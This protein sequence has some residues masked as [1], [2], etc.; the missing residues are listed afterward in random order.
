MLGQIREQRAHVAEAG[1]VNQIATA[2]LAADQA[3]V[4]EFLQMKRQRAR[5]NSELF[6]HGARRQA[7]GPRHH[8]RP[9]RAQT[10]R[11]RQRCQRLHGGRFI[12]DDWVYSD[13]NI[14]FHC[15]NI[16]E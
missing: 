6:G 15:S 16:I 14:R 5:R 12:Y 9:E 7:V 13:I 3:R 4:G 1:A 2:R 8:Q 10:L 11:L